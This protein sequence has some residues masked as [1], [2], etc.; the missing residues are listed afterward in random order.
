MPVLIIP[1][2]IIA[3]WKIHVTERNRQRI[4]NAIY[5]YR[6]ETIYGV[7]VNYDHMEDFYTTLFR[8]WDWGCKR[9]VP[10]EKY[11]AIEPYIER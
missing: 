2:F 9:I 7:S 8:I 4:I 3:L 11:M 5:Q 1:L 10:K 6:R